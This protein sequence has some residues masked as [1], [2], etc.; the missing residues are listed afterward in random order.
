M[1]KKSL[2]IFRRDLRLDDNTA[3]IAALKSSEH[4]IPCFILDPRQ[5]ESH[6]YQSHPG[7][8]FMLQS[9]LDLSNQL[10]QRG[11][12]LYVFQ[13]L[14]HEVVQ[15][16]ISTEAVEAVFINHDYTPFSQKRD[17]QIEQVCR[18][19][20]IDC[21]ALHDT[22]LN[23][24][25]DVRK[26]DGGFYTVYTPYM[27]NALTREVPR[28]VSNRAQNFY[29]KKIKGSDVRRLS[30][31][32]DNDT[33]PAISGGRTQAL[34]ILKKLNRFKKYDELRNIPALDSTTHLSP[35]HKFGTCSV[36]EVF[37]AVCRAF[38]PEHT[39]IKELIWRDFFTQIGYHFPQVLGH[40]FHKKYDK[41]KWDN[42]KKQFKAWC[43]GQTGFPLVDAGMRELNQTGFMHNRVRMVTASFL[44]KDLRVDWR[45]G[46][47]YFA[48][49]LVDY[50]PLVNN[51]NWQW[52]AS[53]GCDAQPY[54]RIFNPWLQ[55]ERYDPDC[56]YIKR[57]IP[58]LKEIPPKAIHKIVKTP[59]NL[60]DYPDPIIDHKT[61]SSQT[62]AMFKSC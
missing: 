4:V 21:V 53:T 15:D 7:L 23:A 55:Q 16:L 33:L 51:G 61:E 17:Q 60:P 58:E 26:G 29:A 2:F 43:E 47:K 37:H 13:G 35:H 31:L 5:I 39:L 6:P 38:G 48:Q 19:H 10:E 40:A 14:P 27:R 3:L 62:L 34:K 11:G 52:A 50:D 44:V 8:M 54:F 1:Y 28:P 57:W 56:A 41:I 49:K 25:E 9:L 42:D 45:W 32:L 36:R 12:M 59:L 20:Q 22:L 46:E 18:K 24:P 30:K